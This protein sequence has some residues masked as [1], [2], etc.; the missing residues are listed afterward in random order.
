MSKPIYLDYN[1]TTPHDPEVIAAMRPFLEKEFGN[2]SSSH[3]YGF[4][5]KKAVMDAHNQIASLI[6]CRPDEII[7]TSGGT[8][9][10]NHAIKGVAHAARD[11]GN[12]IITCRIEHPA[13]LEVCNYL[14]ENGFEITCL[15]VDE[16]GLV[17][18]SDVATAIKSD[19]ILITIMHANN[20]VG[21]IQPIAE[22][23][24]IAKKRGILFHTDA[25]QSIG[26]IPVEVD[27]LGVDLL[28]IAGH[29][30][31]APKGVGALYFRK[32]VKLAKFMHGAGQEAGMRA[33]TENVLEVVGLGKACEIA[34]RNLERNMTHMQQMRDRLYEGIQNECEHVRLNGHPRKRLPNTLSISFEGREANRI[35]DEIG[36]QVT[37]SAGAACHSNRVEIS[38]VLRAMKVPLSWA[39]GTLRLTT[40]RMTTASDIDTVVQVLSKTL[41][42]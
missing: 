21:T 17:S 26:K 32:G 41:K 11:R 30:V 34:K 8:E 2:P 28:S 3:G 16:Q 18:V 6:S 7:F 37:A 10:N 27:K 4:K 14:A 1:A 19:T 25:A 5:P 9:S 31:Y 22:I 36:P 42:K 12:H 39:K 13:V 33:G 40:G 20:E 38:Y 35:L 15:P 24:E 23:A 29:K